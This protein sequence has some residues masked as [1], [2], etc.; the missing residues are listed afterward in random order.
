MGVPSAVHS[1]APAVG[2]LVVPQEFD[3]QMTS[4][5]H[6]LAQSTDSHAF[7]PVQ[8]T[9][10][11]LS[12]QLTFTHVFE[13][14]HITLH[15]A[16]RLQSTSSHVLLPMQEIVQWK[17]SGHSIELHAFAPLQTM[18][19]SIVSTLHVSHPDGQSCSTQNPPSHVRPG[20][21]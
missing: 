9:A 11:W 19:H 6:E 8:V 4:Q 13:P 12:P 7:V 1:V 5:P 3:P 18:R 21:H 15:D 2:Q 20:S 16:E 10:H 17:S 14:E